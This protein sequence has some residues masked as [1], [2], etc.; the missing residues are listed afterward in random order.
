MGAR[1]AAVAE[2]SF[3]LLVKIM[4]RHFRYSLSAGG[5]ASETIDSPAHRIICVAY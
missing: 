5:Y 2:Y 4:L 3:V 1:G